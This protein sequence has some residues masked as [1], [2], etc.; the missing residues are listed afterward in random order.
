M[1]VISEKKFIKISIEYNTSNN[2]RDDIYD[3]LDKKYKKHSWRITRS[4]PKGNGK[5]YE[6]LVIIEVEL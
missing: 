1:K 4:G 3:W 5:K 2:E 6:G